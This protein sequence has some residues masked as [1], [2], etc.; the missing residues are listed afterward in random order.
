MTPFSTQKKEHLVTI[1]AFR[2]HANDEN[3]Y[4]KQRLLNPELLIQT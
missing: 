4:S 2:L 3:A 1:L